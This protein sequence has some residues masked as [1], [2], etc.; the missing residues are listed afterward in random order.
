MVLSL[1]SFTVLLVLA[2]CAISS[3]KVANAVPATTTTTVTPAAH[4]PE[5][6]PGPGLPSLKSLGLTSDDLYKK[7]PSLGKASSIKSQIPFLTNFIEE[8]EMFEKR[9]TLQCGSPGPACD[10]G[11]AWGCYN[12]LNGLGHTNCVVSGAYSN[13]KFCQAGSCSWYGSNIGG[14]SSASSWW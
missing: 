10:V 2:F 3:V 9:F 12:Y 11:S 14:G 8:R 6:I 7:G 1:T 4:Y 13:I 5:V